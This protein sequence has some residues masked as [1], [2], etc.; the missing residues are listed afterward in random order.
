MENK[1]KVLIS[2]D[3]LEELLVTLNSTAEELSHKPLAWSA[4]ILA[5]EIALHNPSGEY[6]FGPL[7]GR[8]FSDNDEE[9]NTE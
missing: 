5:K 7:G 6:A 1:Q 8:L 4:V 9:D 2:R 3:V